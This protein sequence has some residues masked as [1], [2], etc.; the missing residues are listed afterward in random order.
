V[1]KACDHV[2]IILIIL[3]T[4]DSEL[5]LLIGE[6]GPVLTQL[7]VVVERVN[8]H[9]YRPHTPQQYASWFV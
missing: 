7:S 1:T 9:R 5:L 3:T 6:A 8:S 2:A 4:M